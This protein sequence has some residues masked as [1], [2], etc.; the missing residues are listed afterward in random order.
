MKP[1]PKSSA[2]AVVVVAEVA[3]VVAV[4]ATVEDTA[5]AVEAAEIAGRN[6]KIRRTIPRLL[7]LGDN[8]SDPAD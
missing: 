6:S 4:G 2:A 7:V 1:V 3:T 5:A 8:F